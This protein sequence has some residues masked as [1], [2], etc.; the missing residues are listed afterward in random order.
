[1]I[2]GN[3]K[4]LDATMLPPALLKLLTQKE[5]SL[6]A[7]QEKSEGTYNIINND[8]F[9]I[10]STPTTDREE[11]LKSEFHDHYLDIQVVLKGQEMIS[12]STTITY[13]H[14][15][16][17]TKSDLIFLDNPP[18]TTRLLLDTGD[19]AIFYPG[20]VHRPTCQVNASQKIKKA[21]F[22]ISKTWLA[23]QK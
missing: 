16:Q 4:Q 14:Q 23:T 3:L 2:T 7:L 12:T 11:N 1:M 13:P 21:V 10:I 6:N 20:E 15:Y 8:V 19:F 5:L 22:K 9:Y 17:E 18:I